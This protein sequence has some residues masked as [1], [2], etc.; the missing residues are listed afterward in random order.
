MSN[1]SVAGK[2]FRNSA[3]NLLRYL[4][5]FA[6]AFVLTPYIVRSVGDQLYG[7][8]VLVYSFVGYA[9][10]L[11][12]GVMQST[13]KL[14]SQYARP[15]EKEKR[16]EIATVVVLF[17]AGI[18][19]IG[20]ILFW[21]VFESML[22]GL[23]GD[24]VSHE[25]VRSFSHLVGIE[26]LLTFAANPVYGIAYGMHQYHYKS[27]TDILAR[28]L[29]MVFTYMVIES[30]YGLIG[31]AWVRIVSAVFSLLLMLVLCRKPFR[32]IS[33]GLRFISKRAVR[34]IFSFG[35]KIFICQIVTRLN[36]S[37]TPGV[38]TYVL[39]TAM[40]AYYGVCN[41]LADRL[42]EMIGSLA[43]PF[44][45]VF[46]EISS[47]G[48]NGDAVAFYVTGTRMMLAITLPVNLS[49]MFL[50]PDFLNLWVGPAYQEAG[51]FVIII[52]AAESLLDGLQ[53]LSG[54]MIIGG[55]DVGVYTKV[56]AVANVVGIILTFLF[57]NMFGITGAA[58]SNLT[59]SGLAGG[60]VFL[61]LQKNLGVNLKHLFQECY[62]RYVIPVAVFVVTIVYLKN[63]IELNGFLQFF[64]I[65]IL[66]S[67]A[68]YIMVWFVGFN[69]SD[70]DRLKGACKSLI[71]QRR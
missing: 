9:G 24:G 42:K 18:G 43:G 61:L 28:I 41:V 30:G 64:E 3:S 11:E 22:V 63:N 37:L 39:S 14:I 55:G 21:T 12:F 15:E 26:V 33:F 36:S 51:R 10:I 35:S 53:P 57:V 49:L 4:V 71:A 46:S 54:R 27:L 32:A 65:V 17:Y 20:C 50:G 59:R 31:I 13:V 19:V 60:A 23:A 52:L 38:I 7:L 40:T 16:N 66:S 47:N 6:V 1:T 67:L 58:V 62:V 68:F 44:L 69:H 2:L 29:T 70:R 34:E 5:G 8:F 56:I 48:P 45:P 25:M